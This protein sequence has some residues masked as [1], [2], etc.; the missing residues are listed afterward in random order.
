MRDTNNGEMVMKYIAYLYWVFKH[1]NAKYGE[2]EDR[3]SI[4]MSFFGLLI[5]YLFSFIALIDAF[6]GTNL[7]GANGWL[8][9]NTVI[10]RLVKTPLL[11]SPIFLLLWWFLA[12]KKQK[13]EIEV[14][15]IE[16][17]PQNIR[18]GIKRRF[19]IFLICS[20][21]FLLVCITSV[22]WMKLLRQ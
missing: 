20:V 7:H 21:I 8:D 4:L 14:S 5:I 12:L 1:A 10:N 9:D 15:E 22:A 2:V 13:I 3:F 19:V 17:L 16:K 11:M 6:W 18:K